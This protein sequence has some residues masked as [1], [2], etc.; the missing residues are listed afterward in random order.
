MHFSV[1][2][3]PFWANG[4]RSHCAA[5]SSMVSYCFATVEDTF[6]NKGSLLPVSGFGLDTRTPLYGLSDEC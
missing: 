1:G 2:L 3:R 5:T 4:L 6:W